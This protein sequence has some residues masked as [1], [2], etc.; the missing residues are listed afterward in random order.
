MCLANT[1]ASPSDV[2]FQSW[3]ATGCR[4]RGFESYSPHEIFFS[5]IIRRTFG[6][7]DAGAKSPVKRCD[8]QV[9]SC[10]GR[11]GSAKSAIQTSENTS[12][13]QFLTTT[14]T[15]SYRLSL[16]SMHLESI[17]GRAFVQCRE[18]QD[19]EDEKISFEFAH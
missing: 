8:K 13:L 1:S 15:S 14:L 6:R 12:Y 4:D 5:R 7:S 18:E 19:L 16:S 11:N 9:S 2:L 10:S 3:V 17:R